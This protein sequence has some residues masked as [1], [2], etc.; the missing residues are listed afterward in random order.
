VF[1]LKFVAANFTRS[2]LLSV[3]VKQLLLLSATP[4][5]FSANSA[6]PF[7]CI[8]TDVCRKLLPCPAL[9]PGCRQLQN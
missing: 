7:V 8:N 6:A 1:W 3:S 5:K 4:R 9:K 2:R